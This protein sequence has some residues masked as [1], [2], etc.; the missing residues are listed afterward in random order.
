MY[1][2]VYDDMV[3]AKTQIRS[4]IEA[5]SEEREKKIAQLNEFIARFSAGT[6]SSQVTSRQKEVERIQTSE[7]ARSNIPRPY[8]RFHMKSP[9][10]RHPLECKGLSKS[11]ADL[12][13][14]PPSPPI[15]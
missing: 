6:R 2:G 8:L 13:P 15:L 9:S 5:Q 1:H 4:R 11:P 10:G 7:L 12:N 14:L 3:V